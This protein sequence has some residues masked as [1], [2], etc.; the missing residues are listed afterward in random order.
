MSNLKKFFSFSETISGTTYFLRNLLS[1]FLAYLV[2]FGLGF[3]MAKEDVKLLVFLV[4]LFV[5]VYWFS[6]TTIYK[7]FN[8]LFPLQ[9]GVFTVSLLS[10]QLLVVALSEPYDNL[11][12]IPM[13]IVGFI[14]IFKNSNIENHQG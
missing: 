5:P 14:L 8:A 1:S 12:V 11:V 3:A 2:G 6:M 10:V 7:R 4:I 13:A 9:A